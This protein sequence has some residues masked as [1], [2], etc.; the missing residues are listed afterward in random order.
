MLGGPESWMAA[1]RRADVANAILISPGS[2]NVPLERVSACVC[3]LH[4]R[5]SGITRALC[6][7]VDS[8]VAWA[9]LHGESRA[10]CVALCRWRCR[11][12]PGPR[13]RRTARDMT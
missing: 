8:L 2:C 7:W 5:G 4:V 9:S 11:R 3:A 10:L 6:E 13:Q 12:W 1:R